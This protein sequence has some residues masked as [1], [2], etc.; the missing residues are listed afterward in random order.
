MKSAGRVIRKPLLLKSFSWFDHFA[1]ISHLINFL[2]PCLHG[3]LKVFSW[4]I[5]HAQI[6]WIEVWGFYTILCLYLWL[7]LILKGVSLYPHVD[8]LQ[9]RLFVLF[10]TWLTMW[11]LIF[12]HN[13]VQFVIQILRL[14]PQLLLSFLDLFLCWLQK[15]LFPVFPI[16]IP[17]ISLFL[18]S[19]MVLLIWNMMW[20]CIAATTASTYGY[21]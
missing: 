12:L 5:L 20:W 7:E 2:W 16:C 21:T 14:D 15:S 18:S 6:D 17:F 8:D 10:R 19:W 13:E 4:S 11:F 9:M 1:L 3:L